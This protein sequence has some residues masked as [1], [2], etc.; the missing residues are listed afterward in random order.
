MLDDGYQG[1]LNDGQK[2]Y[3]KIIIQSISR[4]N[5]LINALLNVS[6]IEAGKMAVNVSRIDVVSLIDGIVKEQQ[7]AMDA[8]QIKFKMRLPDQPLL[9]MSD[10]LLLREIIANLVSNAIKYTPP[11]GRV[12]VRLNT[13]DG[14]VVFAVRDTGYGIPEKYQSS[15]F[16]K[17]FRA[18][19]IMDKD[20]TGS[21]LGLYMVKQLTEML[22]G[23]LHFK[24]KEN[25][26]S[27]FLVHLP[28]EMPKPRVSAS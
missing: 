22:H 6:K 3:M 4:M 25:A 2:Q 12:S 15:I 21:G 9:M 13:R 26:G 1:E 8:K 14:S 5:E 11:Q 27:V 18:D 17:F 24:S 19:N 23:T 16:T 10:P 28:I 20:T 7:S